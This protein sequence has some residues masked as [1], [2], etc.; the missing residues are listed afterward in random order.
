[1]NDKDLE[2]LDDMLSS[3]AT[4]APVAPRKPVQMTFADTG[5]GA[6]DFMAS[7]GIQA[8][9]TVPD[10]IK[11]WMAHHEFV[12][13]TSVEEVERIV[14]EAIAS[15]RGSLDLETEGLDNRIYFTDEGKPETVHKIVGYCIS[16]G[17]AKKGYYIPVR[18]KPEDGGPTHNVEPIERVEAAITRYCRAAQ[19]VMD[20]DDPDQLSGKKWLKPPQ[21]I[22]DF[23][24][25]SFDQEFLYPVTGIDW[26]HPDGFEDGNLACFVKYSD[27]K[28]LGLKAK[29]ESLLKD[30]DGNPY[31]MIE[32]KELF[33]NRRKI[34]FPS[35][36]PDEPGVVRYAGSDSICTRLLGDHPESVGAMKERKFAGTY[37]IEKQTAQV[38]RVMERNRVL[39]NKAM[40]HRLLVAAEA[41]RE[42]IR[43][44]ITDLAES[45]GFPGFEPGS[46]KQLSDFLFTGA[47]LD[48]SPKPPRNEKSGQ[49]KTDAA[50][51]E[52]LVKELGANAPP[53]LLWI[54]EFRE[55]DKVIGTY[56]ANMD[57]NGDKNGEFRFQ[58]KQTGAATGR[59]SAPS[60]EPEHGYSGIPIHGIPAT[61]DLRQCFEAREGYLMVKNDYA[62]E[63][64]RIVTNLSNEPVWI[65]EF[66]E[67]DGDLH[68]ITARAFF[69]K[70]E[71]SKEERKM[72]KIANFALVYGGGPASIQR[73]TGC[74]K[75]E[76]QRRKQAFDK[77]LPV[78]ATWV[79]GQHTRVKKDLGVFT[80][81]GRWVAIPDAAIREGELDSRGN[82]ITAEDANRI[83]AACE[84][85]ATN[86]PIQ[87]CLQ[88]TARVLTTQGYQTVASILEGG[89]AGWTWTGSNWAEFEILDKGE[90]QYAE[91]ELKDGTIIPCDTRH[92][93]LV[94][95]EEGYEW[96]E[97][98]E[99]RPEDQIATSLARPVQFP[100]SPLPPFEVGEKSNLSPSMPEGC[101]AD[102][103]FWLG[104]YFGDGWK[105]DE[106][107]CLTYC[108]GAHETAMMDRCV[109]FWT[110]WGLNPK[111]KESTHQPAEKVSTRF[112]VTVWSVDLARWLSKLGIDQSNAHMKRLPDRVFCEPLLYRQAFIK[113]FMA[114]DGHRTVNGNP[115]SIHLCQAELLRDVKLLLR[116]VGVESALYGPYEQT[117][118]E[119]RQTTS[120]RLD[121]NQRMFRASVDGTAA[122]LPK[123]HDQQTPAF[124]VKALLEKY[125][126]EKAAS[127][128][129]ESLYNLYLRMRTGG[130]VTLNTFQHMLDTMGY[131]IDQP[132]YGYKRLQAKRELPTRGPTFTLSVKDPLHRFEAEGVITKNSGADIMKIAMILIHKE[133]HKR[134]WLRNGGD[135]SVRM[136]LTVH[137][138]IV[139]EIKY[140]RVL[141]AL[142]VITECM[143]RPTTLARPPYS[144]PWQVPLVT[145]PL[146]GRTWGA[147][148]GC[149]RYKEGEKL[150]GARKIGNW[151]FKKLPDWLAEIL[152][153][154][155]TEPPATPP[156]AEGAPP[157]V[158]APS[159]P[160]AQASAAPRPENL[161][162][163][164]NGV[165]KIAVIRLNKTTRSSIAQVRA[166]CAQHIKED[167]VRLRIVDM[168]DAVLVDSNL[169][170]RVDADELCQSLATMNLS[171]G[172]YALT[173]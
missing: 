152:A 144:P 56:L 76:A 68:S 78:F 157:A 158:P 51:L 103:W 125:P 147:E 12:L 44:K 119:G 36:S 89:G 82:R 38:K 2:E 5:D 95:T 151:V 11:P 65:K 107:G 132:V 142:D 111:V 112:T 34:N 19:P 91:I 42:E 108:F 59:F 70:A 41:K 15:G 114:S 22:I 8:E 139:F 55:Q 105:G 145:D 160:T 60:G 109:G 17:D 93:L 7:A 146:I 58:F 1:M 123:F 10:I 3:A 77:A 94:I 62:G 115:Y 96:R 167:G 26:W 28:N 79:K 23:W 136:L 32:L 140:H 162:E 113:G 121:I 133:L 120:Y 90:W 164:S 84:R 172:E 63:E 135:D 66:T 159:T 102:L 118:T 30:P 4:P 127:F 130:S 117:D 98:E 43:K 9:R 72:G 50:T 69:N 101:E 88:P 99:L 52:E 149:H 124:L 150:D 18:H 122:R 155:G 13:V 116:T 57:A 16:Y 25:A 67:G 53:V 173:T 47:G 81:F 131:R 61:S 14:D 64:L 92:K 46:P 143:E 75:L 138:E 24:H 20:P 106:R 31:E 126:M 134:R 156:P 37:R 27:D 87:G 168:M 39:I 83:R 73:A 86:Y 171:N 163:K 35:L 110:R 148:T 80:A 129:N 33:P 29:A 137:D 154:G 71:V 48:I 21:V 153:P 169:G 165:A 49:F 97:Y 141:E 45:K 128:P 161:A 40:V 166:L 6:D 85:H 100:G 74:D 104:Y 54:V 170:I